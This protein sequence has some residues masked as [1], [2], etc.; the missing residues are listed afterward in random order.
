MEH[1][2]YYCQN[3][4]ADVSVTMTEAGRIL[5]WIKYSAYGVASRIPVG[6]YNRD[7]AVNGTDDSDFYFDFTG[8][9]LART[10]IDFD[11]SVDYFDSDAWDLDYAE[12]LYTGRGEV[13]QS[14]GSAAYNRLGYAGY[15]FEPATQQYLVRNRE[16][17]PLVGTWDERDPLN[18]HDGADL[19]MYVKDMPTVR[20]DAM[21]LCGDIG[22]GA[23]SSQGIFTSR[24]GNNRSAEWQPLGNPILAMIPTNM[25]DNCWSDV[26]ESAENKQCAS[27][28][29]AD[30]D[31]GGATWC[32][33]DRNINQWI[34]HCCICTTNIK[35]VY[36]NEI[37]RDYVIECTVVHE[38][39]HMN[40]GSC[41]KPRPNYCEEVDAYSAELECLRGKLLECDRDID[42]A[43]A[44]RVVIEQAIRNAES[45][46]FINRQDC[47][48]L[49]RAS[50]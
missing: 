6:D 22:G 35:R 40:N 17:D 39:V 42:A 11:G 28:C 25:V 49:P 27:Q 48:G 4:R 15:F 16:L 19:Y 10:D 47:L 31:R 41:P 14:G 32:E 24:F 8:T 3:W 43:P 18:Y 5:E 46:I 38:N 23:A 30:A 44:C 29:A 12:S 9:P 36:P 2:V 34:R 13:A 7:G 50:Q 26:G 45:M 21:G 33:F 37:G 1:R 20:R